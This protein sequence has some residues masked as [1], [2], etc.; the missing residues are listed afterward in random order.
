MCTR[1]PK[2]VLKKWPSTQ[3]EEQKLLLSHGAHRKRDD[4]QLKQDIITATL[5]AGTLGPGPRLAR[6]LAMHLPLTRTPCR[7]VCADTEAID[8]KFFSKDMT[9]LSLRDGPTLSSEFAVSVRVFRGVVAMATCRPADCSHQYRWCTWTARLCNGVRRYSPLTS[10][11]AFSS[12]MVMSKRC[13]RRV[14][15]CAPSNCV[16]AV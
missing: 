5:K 9:S 14:P 10:P 11:V 13:S 6:W 8:M 12:W 7:I 4:M 3:A 1:S 2:T 16:V 15:V